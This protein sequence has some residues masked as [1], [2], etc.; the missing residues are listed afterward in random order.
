MSSVSFSSCSLVYLEWSIKVALSLS[1]SNF[2][3]K[4]GM[5][6]GVATTHSHTHLSCCSWQG[7]ES[8]QLL[9][10]DRVS[11]F[12]TGAITRAAHHVQTNLWHKITVPSYHKHISGTR[13]KSCWAGHFTGWIQLLCL[14]RLVSWHVPRD[15]RLSGNMHET[16]SIPYVDVTI[17]WLWELFLEVWIQDLN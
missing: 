12:S 13:L 10:M 2:K 11:H 16:N 9:V 6:V 17:W 3:R 14:L 7:G 5:R 15:D 1:N 4:D 8:D